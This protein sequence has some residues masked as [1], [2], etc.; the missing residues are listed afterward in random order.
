MGLPNREN[1]YQSAAAM[2][3]R[4]KTGGNQGLKFFK[5]RL[6]ADKYK[7]KSIKAFFDKGRGNKMAKEKKKTF[8]IIGIV[9]VI[10]GLA[11]LGFGAYTHFIAAPSVAVAADM[12]PIEKPSN[13]PQMFGALSTFFGVI[14][15]V[16]GTK[17][18][19]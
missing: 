18:E 17:K 11:G 8:I 5:S 10:A 16:A 14:C 12:T 7:V 9:L 13:L 4:R 2:L 6:E 3:G 15:L 1:S 19:E